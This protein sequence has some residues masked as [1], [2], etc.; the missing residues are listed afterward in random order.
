[1]GGLKPHITL[2][3]AL[4]YFCHYLTSRSRRCESL[5][6]LSHSRRNYMKKIALAAATAL[7]ALSACGDAA[8]EAPAEEAVVEEA[9]VEPVAED[10]ADA[11]A[12]VDAAEEAGDAVEEATDEAAEEAP[13]E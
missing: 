5:W 13:A 10:A 3:L 7:F 12:A 1:M 4:P 2:P 6:G 11:D 8:E 9:V